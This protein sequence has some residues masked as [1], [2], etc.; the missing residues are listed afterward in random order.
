[1]RIR[2]ASQP[3]AKRT[4]R[5][6]CRRGR[7]ERVEREAALDEEAAGEVVGQPGICSQVD[8]LTADRLRVGARVRKLL[9]LYGEQEQRPG[10]Q[11]EG[12]VPVLLERAVPGDR[13]VEEL[14]DP[15]RRLAEEEAAVAPGSPRSDAAAV[16]DEHARTGLG[17]K[18]RR[19]TACDAGSDDDR[20]WRA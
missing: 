6:R 16:D 2:L 10:V 14:V 1:M 18:T 5:F 15:G 20:V 4:R 9:L 11:I 19:R 3:R 17:E 12:H 8:L 7:A 13:L